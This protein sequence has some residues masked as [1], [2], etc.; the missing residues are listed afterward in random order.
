MLWSMTRTIISRYPG[1]K[2]CRPNDALFVDSE[3]FRFDSAAQASAAQPSDGWTVQANSEQI[4]ISYPNAPDHIQYQII[5]L[6][7]DH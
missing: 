7:E 3:S 6:Q 1:W 5:S 4:L 2:R